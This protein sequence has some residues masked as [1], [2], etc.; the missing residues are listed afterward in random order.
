MATVDE[1][2]KLSRWLQSLGD[3]VKTDPKGAAIDYA[4][5]AAGG[6]ADL[7]DFVRG[8]T[9]P[10]SNVQPLGWGD[11]LRKALGATGSAVEDAGNLFGVPTPAGAAAKAGVIAKGWGPALVAA[12]GSIKKVREAPKEVGVGK[13]FKSGENKGILRG[14]EAFGGITPQKMTEMRKDYVVKAKKGAPY[15]KY[16]YD[17]TSEALLDLTGRNTDVA[18][19]LVEPMAILSATTPVQSNTMYGFKGWNQY[20][21]GDRV[22]TGKYPGDMG[23][24]VYTAI[25]EGAQASGL[26]RSPYA[27]GLSVAWRPDP[28][29]MAVND[30]H[31]IAAYGIIDPKTGKPWRR[32]AGDAQHRVLQEQQAKVVNTLNRDAQR[33]LDAAQISGAMPEEIAQLDRPDWN[34]YRSQAAAWSTERNDKLG[35]PM[36]E[37]GKHY[38][39]FINEYVANIT[40][41]WAPGDNTGMWGEW[42]KLPENVR[43]TISNQL[44]SEIIGKAYTDKLATGMGA[45][46]GKTLANAGQYEGVKSPGFVSQIPVGKETGSQAMDESSRKLVEAIAAGHGLLMP[47]K[48][49][50]YNYFGSIAPKSEAGG[51]RFVTG[52]RM[53]PQQISVLQDDLIGTGT[54]IAQVDPQGARALYFNP[55]VSDLLHG[56]KETDAAMSGA[57]PGEADAFARS[58][59]QW[60]QEASKPRQEWAKSVEDVAQKHGA[61]VE[62]HAVDSN[63]FPRDENYNAPETWSALPYMDAIERAGPQVVENFNRAVAP[64]ASGVLA[65]VQS[66]AQKYGLTNAPY[67]EPM[68]NALQSGDAINE[69]KRLR[70]A[71][72][73]PMAAL[74]ALGLSSLLGDDGMSGSY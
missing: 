18:D 61:Q 9:I 10:G 5:G 12:L 43:Q 7:A 1:L 16:W 2:L 32:G 54:D 36:D 46:S 70:A 19:R 38:G 6:V 26:K 47:Q 52:E 49:V 31:N 57:M 50:A 51:V 28:D 21:V 62:Y 39:D 53:R 45:L 72:I 27:G 55:T 33:E 25:D 34:K 63:I 29:L 40:R 65:R 20:A 3:Q 66:A 56:Q 30:I 68:M 48:Q 69:L 11:S 23:A 35:V 17:E 14:T 64:I 41:E 4:R 22:H 71:G 8:G 42:W 60:R 44:E 74:T 15:S 73:V 13:V 67:Y 37:A 24:Q 58:L 59:R